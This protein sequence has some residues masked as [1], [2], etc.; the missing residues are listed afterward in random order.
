M[1]SVARPPRAS[2]LLINEAPLQVIP[3]LARAIGLNEAIFAQQVHYWISGKSGKEHD[4]RRWIYNTREQWQEQFIFW[5]KDTITRTV[6]S[7]KRQGVL[8][9]SNRLNRSK[10]DRTLWY[11]L[12]YARID[13]IAESQHDVAK[14]QDG[15]AKAQH[16]DCEIAASNQET[17]HETIPEITQEKGLPPVSLRSTSPTGERAYEI[18]TP[19]AISDGM[20]RAREASERQRSKLRA[21]RIEQRA[22]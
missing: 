21:G 5:S 9:T 3:S 14:S 13:E 8:L 22:R 19:V 18:Q 1:N 16:G 4:G 15:V 11:T 7:L 17:T 20:I 6:G 10:M 2:N 12:D